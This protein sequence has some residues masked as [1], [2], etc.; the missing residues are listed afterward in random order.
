MVK[1]N[2]LHGPHAVKLHLSTDLK[3]RIASLA[4]SLD[5]P[6][7]EVCRELL[8]MALPIVEGMHAARAVGNGRGRAKHRLAGPGPMLCPHPSGSVT[9]DSA[10]GGSGHHVVFSVLEVSGSRSDRPPVAGCRCGLHGICWAAQVAGG[11]R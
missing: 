5:R 1:F 2:R 7:A 4:E 6:I 9:H 11:A 3:T 10:R 8:F